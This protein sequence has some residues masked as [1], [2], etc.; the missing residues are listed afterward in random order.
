MTHVYLFSNLWEGRW[1]PGEAR[2]YLEA[3]LDAAWE[4]PDGLAVVEYAQAAL[5]RETVLP[6]D[7][8]VV[9]GYLS[10][11]PGVCS[12]MACQAGVPVWVVR[13][14]VLP[15]WICGYFTDLPA[16]TPFDVGTAIRVKV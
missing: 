13:L 9:L 11:L 14:P 6:E 5:E 10:N 16:W 7:L 3:A 15:E 1:H 12:L 2:A 8:I 4:R